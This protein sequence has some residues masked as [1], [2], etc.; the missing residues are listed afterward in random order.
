MNKF[1]LL[2]LASSLTCFAFSDDESQTSNQNSSS[3]FK[4]ITPSAFA[5][6]KEGMKFDI[7]AD[8]IYWICGETGL[9]AGEFNPNQTRDSLV[10]SD[11]KAPQQQIIHAETK[12]SP[13][14]KVGAGMT[15]EHDGWDTQLEYTWYHTKSKDNQYSFAAIPT[16]LY[17]PNFF[18]TQDPFYGTA[19]AQRSF[20]PEWKYHFN[21]FNLE[22][23]RNFYLSHYLTL[24]PH[25]G[26]K[27]GWQKQYWNNNWTFASASPEENDSKAQLHDWTDAKYQTNMKGD[28]W[29]IGLRCGFDSNWYFSKNWA[30]LGDF[31]FANLWTYLKGHRTDLASTSGSTTASHNVS[32]IETLKFFTETHDINYVFEYRL[33]LLY[34]VWMSDDAYRLRFEAAWETQLWGYFPNIYSSDSTVFNGLLKTPNMQGLTIKAQFDF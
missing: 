16:Y 34:D 25:I 18:F 11:Y 3:D 28:F 1:Y 7:N 20:K 2:C 33:G 17:N 19:N 31:S 21:N 22:L 24:R 8:F 4:T 26:I 5:I 27:G 10:S 9:T 12:F 6:P 32:N 30:L 13:G 14:F 23:G 29:N 15:Y